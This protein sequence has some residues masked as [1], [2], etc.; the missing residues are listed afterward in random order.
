MTSPSEKARKAAFGLLARRARTVREMEEQLGRLGFEGGI[1][2]EII[3]EL[4]R[5]GYL[6][7]RLFARQYARARAC[8][9]LWGNRRIEAELL[10]KGIDRAT[11]RETLSEVRRDFPEEEGLVSYLRGWRRRASPG[12]GPRERRRVAAR[13]LARGFP[14]GLVYEKLQTSEEVDDHGDDIQ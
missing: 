5:L 12:D 8:D 14:A 11:I 13:L 9:H 1:I 10:K 2:K 4:A 3:A 7:D 6:D